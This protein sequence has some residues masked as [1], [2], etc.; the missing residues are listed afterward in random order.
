MPPQR[1]NL[2]LSA[3]VPDGELD[4]LVL[5]CL[6][7]ETDCGNGGDDFTQLELVQDRSLSGSVQ[8]DHQNSHL[9]LA[10]KAVKQLREGET[11]VGGGVRW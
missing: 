4:V 1:S 6:D 5:D 9:L 3:N 2:V 10:P 8:S 7:V 11:H